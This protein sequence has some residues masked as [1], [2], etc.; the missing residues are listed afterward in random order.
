MVSYRLDGMMLSKDEQLRSDEHRHR[1]VRAQAIGS[2]LVR[3]HAGVAA[4]PAR[5]R[6]KSSKARNEIN[7][8][9]EIKE[10]RRM[11]SCGGIGFRP[12][13]GAFNPRFT[14]PK[15]AV[16]PLDDRGTGM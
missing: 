1:Q 15:A 10:K 16:L 3:V 7:E 14:A 4:L 2:M 11:T 5:I 8:Q 9:K 12:P 13:V 6:G